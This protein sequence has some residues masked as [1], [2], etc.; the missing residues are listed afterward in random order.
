[1]DFYGKV[2]DKYPASLETAHQIISQKV[3][4]KQKLKSDSPKFA[5]IMMESEDF[6]YQNSIDKFKIV[7]PEKSLDLVEEGRY[8]CH[9]VAS[10]IEKVNN[11]DCIV[12]FM[13]EK[14]NVELPYLTIEILPN[15]SV[16]QVEGMN[17][18]SELSEEEI[19]FINRW[20]KSKHLKVAAGNAIM[21]KEMKKKNKETL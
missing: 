5:E 21:T 9:C 1:M 10:Y 14:E 7:M 8:L 12:V 17:K 13:R 3:N 11:G 15:R 18:R 2:R 6:S 4:E 19:L 20:A 16:V